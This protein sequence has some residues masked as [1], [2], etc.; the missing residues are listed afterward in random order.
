MPLAPAYS[1][2]V[3]EIRYHKSVSKNLKVKPKLKSEW[4]KSTNFLLHNG[5][6]GQHK[7]HI[8]LVTYQ[9]LQQ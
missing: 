8:L 7:D 9:L 2:G 1:C 6:I 3:S 5:H 4:C